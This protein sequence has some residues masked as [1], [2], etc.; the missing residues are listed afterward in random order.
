MSP[1]AEEAPSVPASTVAKTPLKSVPTTVKKTAKKTES[2]EEVEEVAEPAVLRRG[3]RNRSASTASEESVSSLAAKV[4]GKTVAVTTSSF[5]EQTVSAVEVAATASKRGRKPKD[6][7]PEE[8]GEAASSSTVIEEP[9]TKAPTT[10]SKKGRKP[11]EE[12]EKE[13]GK[14]RELRSEAEKEDHTSG[15]KSKGDK[16]EEPKKGGK[17]EQLAEK[18]RE[19]EELEKKAVSLDLPAKRTRANSKLE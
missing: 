14:K 10:A 5:E 17:V 18:S 13:A 6:K 1:I 12:S 9:A 15:K 19:K 16:V 2:V 3:T 4:V 11:V 7:D 8:T